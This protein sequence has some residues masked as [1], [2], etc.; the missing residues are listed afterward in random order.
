MKNYFFYE[1]N[2]KILNFFFKKNKNYLF[3]KDKI[4]KE[5]LSDINYIQNDIFNFQDKADINYKAIKIADEIYNLEQLNKNQIINKSFKKSFAINIEEIL[6]TV[7][8]CEKIKSH[9]QLDNLYICKFF[10]D[11][12]LFN[13]L[14]K[15]KY[16]SDEIRISKI[17]YIFN[18]L[19]LFIENLYFLLKLLFLPELAIFL[20]RKNFNENLNYIF[21]VDKEPE[22]KN[23]GSFLELKKNLKKKSLVVKDI[24]LRDNIFKKNQKKYS[25]FNLFYL[26]NIFKNISLINYIS[27]FYL[28]YFI[29]RF[30]LIF[31]FKCSYKELYRYFLT[32]VCWEIFLNCFKVKKS[33]T[34]ML[35]SNV[36]SQIIQKKY[37][38]ETIF[39]YF[40]STPNLTSKINDETTVDQVQYNYMDYSTLI[41][42]KISIK[43][44]KKDTNNFK[45][46]QDFGTIVA[47]QASVY[48]NKKKLFKNTL[49]IYDSKKIVGVFDNLIGFNG[50]L[51]NKEYLEFTKYLNFLVKKYKNFNFILNK[52][53][54]ES[55]FNS[56][57]SNFKEINFELKKLE[58]NKNYIKFKYDLTTPQILS[59]SDYVLTHPYSS[60]IYE[61]LNSEKETF[62]YTGDDNFIHSDKD[63]LKISNKI[64]ININSKYNLLDKEVLNN[65]KIKSKIYLSQNKLQNNK[66]F[67]DKFYNYL[68]S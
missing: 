39:F 11:L 36:T 19:Y 30:K 45:N 32:K 56:D 65:H 42:N 28:K 60:I 51:S 52:K 63:Y 66:N 68:E 5:F 15:N 67:F 17:Y 29:E 58:N 59:I 27:K 1:S 41:S 37:I 14:Q 57:I 2:I 18:K 26:I 8:L 13:Y 25:D 4:K 49:N 22:Y 34:A 47:S 44:F 12:N 61:A 53:G 9:Y 31:L 48:K 33:L 20:C 43:Y 3:K 38:D 62:I 40:S 16:I 7:F 46:Y 6:R 21:I 55:Y 24:Q 10:N 23:I 64:S 50:I 35:P 54:K